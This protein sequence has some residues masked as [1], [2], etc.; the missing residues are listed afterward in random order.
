MAQGAFYFGEWTEKHTRGYLELNS[1]T[2]LT[3]HNRWGGIENL[4]QVKNACVMV[5]FDM[6][7]GTNHRLNEGDT[8]RLEPEGVWHIHVNP[9]EQTS[10]TYFHFE[11]DIRHIVEEII[12]KG[13][14]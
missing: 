3:I 7:N 5:V 10:L 13:S 11:G 8:L 1:H 14:E 4:T 6:E 12:Q 2:S 9:F